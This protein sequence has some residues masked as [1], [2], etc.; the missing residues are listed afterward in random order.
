MP[1]RKLNL[2]QIQF[3]YL[4]QKLGINMTH[5][6]SR[7]SKSS[8][9]NEY[10]FYVECTCTEE[11]KDKLLEELKQLSSTVNVLSRNPSKDEGRCVQV[12]CL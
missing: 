10:D 4:V 12:R 8:P 9:G 1:R 11:L 7:P 2:D 6:E 5:L 3:V